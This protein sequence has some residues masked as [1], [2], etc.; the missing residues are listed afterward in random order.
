M[1]ASPAA[2]NRQLIAAS[3]SEEYLL[4]AVRELARVLDY[5]TYHTWRSDHSDAGYPD[6]HC[7][8]GKR[9]VFMELKS[10]RGRLTLP[11]ADWRQALQEAGHEH[12]V[13]RPSD[14]LS[15]EIERVLRGEA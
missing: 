9:S 3:M 12:Y 5:H 6:L 4:Q 13:F 8:K 2:A 7:V 1:T 15:G 11:Q 14:W 10:Q